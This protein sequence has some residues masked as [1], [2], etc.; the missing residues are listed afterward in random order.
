MQTYP[1]SRDDTRKILRPHDSQRL[2]HYNAVALDAR[3]QWPRR[4]KLLSAILDVPQLSIKRWQLAAQVNDADV[5]VGAALLAATGFRCF[6]H[7]VS[8]PGSLFFRAYRQ[9]A[10]IPSIPANLYVYGRDNRASLILGDEEVSLSHHL[11]HSFFIGP[12][13][14]QEGLDGERRVD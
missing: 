8:K 11:R 1:M 9:H 4:S 2:G 3:P 13:T 10:K 12:G 14:I 5:D 6:N 7:H